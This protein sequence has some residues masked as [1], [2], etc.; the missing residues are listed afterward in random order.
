MTITIVVPPVCYLFALVQVVVLC[1]VYPIAAATPEEYLQ[2]HGVAMA[3]KETH[4][5]HHCPLSAAQWKLSH[6]PSS[7][8]VVPNR[9]FYSCSLLVCLEK[10][11]QLALTTCSRFSVVCSPFTQN[12]NV[13]SHIRTFYTS[14]VACDRQKQQI[15]KYQKRLFHFLTQG[16]VY[17]WTLEVT[18][19]HFVLTVN[20]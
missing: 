9:P 1:S 2:S 15:V 3:K 10:F 14:L 4:F 7:S 13:L 16:Q 18:D 6:L 19:S 12:G 5:F 8:L 17:L 11:V 20:S